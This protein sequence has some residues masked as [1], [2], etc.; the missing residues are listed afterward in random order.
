MWKKTIAISALM[1]SG[2]AWA[3]TPIG[4]GATGSGGTGM[5]AADANIRPG[6]PGASLTIREDGM[7]TD[8]AD[9]NLR[10]GTAKAPMSNARTVQPSSPDTARGASSGAGAFGAVEGA[11]VDPKAAIDP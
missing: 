9:V 6:G 10:R 4:P 7:P 3:D 11:Q 2:F 5:N 8:S 1:L